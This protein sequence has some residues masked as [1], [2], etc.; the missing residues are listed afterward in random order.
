MLTY[1]LVSFSTKLLKLSANLLFIVITTPRSTL[2]DARSG[3]KGFH[4]WKSFSLCN[5]MNKYG[6]IQAC[7]R[8]TKDGV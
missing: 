8:M 7:I 5:V 4:I 2:C 6:E 1:P 3:E